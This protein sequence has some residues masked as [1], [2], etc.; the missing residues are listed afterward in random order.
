MPMSAM[1]LTSVPASSGPYFGTFAGGFNESS[2]G[3][4]IE[5]AG[6][7]GEHIE[8]LSSSASNSGDVSYAVPRRTSNLQSRLSWH[9]P[10]SV[11]Q[12]FANLQQQQQ[13]HHHHQQQQRFINTLGVSMGGEVPE[14]A[15]PMMGDG[16]VMAMGGDVN[17]G[18]STVDWTMLAGI[19]GQAHVTDI[20][21]STPPP[22]SQLQMQHMNGIGAIDGHVAN[23]FHG[24]GHSHSVS[25][26]HGGIGHGPGR[27]SSMSA[28]DVAAS[29]VMV[30]G[31]ESSG[32]NNFLAL[33]DDLL[34]DPS[35]LMT[36]LGQDLSGWQCP[37]KTN[38]IDPAAL[39]AVDPESNNNLM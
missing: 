36:V 24:H 8:S 18:T 9:G 12:A 38:T 37:T 5:S 6:M 39:C 34:R 16:N 23:Q 1:D 10:E 20:S 3:P 4:S 31:S 33:Y 21:M 26:S 19:P 13:N 15:L 22:V 14:L 30:S 35:S 27:V 25:V 29:G 11:T 32:S 28:M 2:I 17:V 7:F